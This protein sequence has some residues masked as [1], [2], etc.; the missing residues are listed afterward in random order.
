MF[1]PLRISIVAAAVGSVLILSHPTATQGERPSFSG[2]WNINGDKTGEVKDVTLSSNIGVDTRTMTTGQRR[3]GST[4]G[5]GGGGG[6]PST[7]NRGGGGPLPAVVRSVLSPASKLLIELS[8]SSITVDPGTGYIVK[9]PTDGKVHEERLEDGSVFKTK[10]TWRRDELIVERDFNV[11]GTV[12]GATR[13]VFR[14]DKSDPRM[15]VVDFHFEHKAYRRT[16]DQRR[17]YNL[18]G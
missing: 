5:G 14:L 11:A 2:T 13:E 16:V 1:I 9:V 3:A 15:L 8:D 17:V 4:G 7:S 12:S 10:A 18:E 6:S